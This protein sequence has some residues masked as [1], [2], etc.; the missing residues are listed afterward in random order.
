MT[1]VARPERI[2]D[3][4][5]YLMLT[6]CPGVRAAFGCGASGI[7]F[8]GGVVIR[9]IPSGG[10]LEPFTWAVNLPG[11]PLLRDGSAT[12]LDID[13]N[14]ACRLYLDRNDIANAQQQAA[15]F[16]GRMLTAIHNTSQLGGTCNSSRI[17]RFGTGGDDNAIWLD[18]T[19]SAWERLNLNNQPGAQWV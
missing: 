13:W 18:V 12:V 4:L 5:A 3:A 1:D 19:V 8:P 10:H 17:V 16:Y 2:V 11:A 9:P 6:Q 15:P 7:T 14:L